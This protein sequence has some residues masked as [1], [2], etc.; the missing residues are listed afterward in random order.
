MEWDGE[1]RNAEKNKLLESERK[2][3]GTEGECLHQ[4]GKGEER[5]ESRGQG[6]NGNTG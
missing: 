4:G 3:N 1:E 2:K 5:K 6:K